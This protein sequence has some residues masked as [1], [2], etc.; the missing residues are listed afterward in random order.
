MTAHL[1]ASRQ[2]RSQAIL[3][4]LLRATAAVHSS[5]LTTGLRYLVFIAHILWTYVSL[6]L[7]HSNTWC[8]VECWFHICAVSCTYTIVLMYVWS[9]CWQFKE[10]C[11]PAFSFTFT[12]RPKSDHPSHSNMSAHCYVCECMPLQRVL[13]SMYIEEYL[14]YISKGIMVHF[15]HLRWK[16]K[17]F[18]YTYCLWNTWKFPT[19]KITPYNH[20]D[21]P[22]NPYLHAWFVTYYFA[23][24]FLTY[25]FF[26][27]VTYMPMILQ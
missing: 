27:F 6:P 11:F 4:T 19:E 22:L 25:Y 17:Y 23:H 24:L 14:L 9:V 10:L 18:R 5:N 20:A 16:D 3:N 7:M 26:L 12:V 13:L 15:P 1:V 21:N 2:G 8:R